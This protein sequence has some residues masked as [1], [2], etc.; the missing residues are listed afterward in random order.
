MLIRHPKCEGKSYALFILC[1]I[2]RVL[3]RFCSN[4]RQYS[5][6]AYDVILETHKLYL[7]RFVIHSEVILAK[8]RP[9]PGVETKSPRKSVRVTVSMKEVFVYVY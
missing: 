6:I 5:A 9:K 3:M 2:W 1:E 7:C 4:F 8:L